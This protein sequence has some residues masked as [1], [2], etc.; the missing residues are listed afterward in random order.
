MYVETAKK[1]ESGIGRYAENELR[2]I[3]GKIFDNRIHL[4]LK[5]IE[6]LKQYADK[7]TY[8]ILKTFKTVNY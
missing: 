6:N 5:D 1:T 3:L 4:S 7:G 8:D 2:L